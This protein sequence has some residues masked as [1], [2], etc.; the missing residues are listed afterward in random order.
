VCV[1]VYIY[2]YIYICIHTHIYIYNY[3]LYTNVYEYIHVYVCVYTHTY[4]YIHTYMYI[5]THTHTYICICMYVY[6]C[7]SVWA[8]VLVTAPQVPLSSEWIKARNNI[9]QSLF[10]VV[11]AYFQAA[12]WLQVQSL[13]ACSLNCFLAPVAVW[14]SVTFPLNR[15]S[16]FLDFL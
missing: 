3:I 7:V 12:F 6:I 5:Y 9:Q 1:C 11:P 10:C 4:I 13:F 15:N 16:S 2:I 14:V 8:A